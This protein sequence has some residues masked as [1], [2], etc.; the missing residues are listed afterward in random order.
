M[1]QHTLSTAEQTTANT[2]AIV[3]NFFGRLAARDPDG[4]ASLFAEQIDWY[5]PGDTGLPW[6]GHRS[7]RTDVADYFRTMW[8]HF[9]PGKSTASV[10]KLIVSGNDAIMLGTFSHTAA[11]TGRSWNTPVAMHL[12]VDGGKIVKLY[13]YEDTWAV[14]KAFFD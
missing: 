14:S 11:S 4:M 2:Q 12:A 13:L 3:N 8:P 6:I 1:E 7:H 5:V 9:E 10:E